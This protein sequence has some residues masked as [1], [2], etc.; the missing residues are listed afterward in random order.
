MIERGIFTQYSI[1]EEGELDAP[2][3][4][5]ALAVFLYR[6]ARKIDGAS[7]L[8][9]DPGDRGLPGKDAVVSILVNG[10]AVQ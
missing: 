4:L 8:K 5:K 3:S 10:E 9:G 7:G 1:D 2:V 6:I